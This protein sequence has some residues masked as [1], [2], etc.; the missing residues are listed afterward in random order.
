MKDDEYYREGVKF[1]ESKHVGI[2]VFPRDRKA[3]EREEGRE[4]G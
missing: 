4:T 1:K 2:G 3:R